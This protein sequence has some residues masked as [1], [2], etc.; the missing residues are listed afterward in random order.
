MAEQKI[1]EAAAPFSMNLRSGVPVVIGEGDLYYSDDEVVRRNPRAWREVTVNRSA[2]LPVST[3][4]ARARRQDPT[5]QTPPPPVDTGAEGSSEGT[6][7]KVVTPEDKVPDPKPAA[8][9]T[10]ARKPAAKPAADK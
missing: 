5:G 7:D 2:P 1:M 3:A 9:K 8:P 4:P 10:T 6:P